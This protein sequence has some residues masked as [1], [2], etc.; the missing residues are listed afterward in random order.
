MKYRLFYLTIEPH[1]KRLIS[2][3]FSLL[4]LQVFFIC[5]FIDIM[6][7]VGISNGEGG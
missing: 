4:A 5:L 7:N 6:S 3:F 1:S 2:P